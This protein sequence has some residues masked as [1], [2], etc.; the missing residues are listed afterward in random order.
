MCNNYKI[1]IVR[2]K[3]LV[4]ENLSSIWSMERRE[5]L[6]RDGESWA[7][8]CLF[9]G[10][11]YLVLCSMFVS[12]LAVFMRTVDRQRPTYVHEQSV[13]A[14]GTDGDNRAN[15]LNPGLGFRPQLDPESSFMHYSMNKNESNSSDLLVQAIHLYLK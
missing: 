6:G 14:Y 7:K 8:I 11:F 10:I 3:K 13:M 9:Y 12:L 15:T 1:N 4:K 5:F 2:L